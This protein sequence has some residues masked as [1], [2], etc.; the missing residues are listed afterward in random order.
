MYMES[1]ILFDQIPAVFGEVFAQKHFRVIRKEKAREFD[2]RMMVLESSSLKIRFTLERG[3]VNLAVST[4][5]APNDWSRDQ[6]FDL[7][8]L[9]DYLAE[10]KVSPLLNIVHKVISYFIKHR[11]RGAKGRSIVHDTDNHVASV[12]RQLN[13]LKQKFVS[14]CDEIEMLFDATSFAREVT[15]LNRFRVRRDDNVLSELTGKW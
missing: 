2:Y 14:S 11:N 15:S 13:E 5:G 6:W 10:Q 3:F 1:D 8:I 12:L 9:L 4:L 7:D